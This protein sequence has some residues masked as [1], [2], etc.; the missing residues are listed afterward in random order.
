MKFIALAF[1]FCLAVG[2]V[3][4]AVKN[5]NRSKI[6]KHSKMKAHSKVKRAPKASKVKRSH[7][8]N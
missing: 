4:A 1:A 7:R 2:P 6:A 5:P 8:A 3:S